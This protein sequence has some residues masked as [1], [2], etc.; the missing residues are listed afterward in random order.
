MH[1]GRNWDDVVG[2]SGPEDPDLSMISFRAK[3]GRP[4]AVLANF[5]MHYFSGHAGVSAD[6]FGHYVRA[7][8]QR[9]GPGD[10]EFVAILSQGTSGDLWRADYSRPAP[11]RSVTIE[12]YAD[13]LATL[14]AEALAGLA[15]RGDVPLAMA[16]QRLVIGRRVPDAAR[17]AWAREIVTGMDGRRPKDQRE[18]YAEQAI[19][20][21]ENPAA[22]V[23]LQALRIGEFGI[24]AMPNDTWLGLTRC[25]R[26]RRLLGRQQ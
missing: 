20:L 18:V 5:S 21:H 10:P 26:K 16:E 1:A 15:Y 22:E 25:T 9:V 17:L 19:Y 8:A 24:T 23:V 4:I 2:E 7:V 11:E 6:Y 14:S 13:R 12:Q 3:D